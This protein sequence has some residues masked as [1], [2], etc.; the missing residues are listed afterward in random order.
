MDYELICTC[1]SSVVDKSFEKISNVSNS[2]ALLFYNM[3][4]INWAG[5][6]FLKDDELYLGPFQGKIACT[7][8]KKG[9]GVCWECVNRGETVIVGNVHNFK[10]HIACDSASLSEIVVPIYKDGEI[11]GVLD[12]DS[13]IE[14]R[15]NNLD[16]E[17]LEK[18]V[19]IIEEII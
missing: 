3:E 4:N 2:C 10:T 16:R 5:Y 17:G 12:I 13:P 11:I 9:K 1:L 6:Y 8:L 14:N 15:F 18:F 7:I 19:S